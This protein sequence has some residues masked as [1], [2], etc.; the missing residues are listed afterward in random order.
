[1]PAPATPQAVLAARRQFSEARTVSDDL[2]PRPILRSWERCAGLGFDMEARPRVEP[3]TEQELRELRERHALLR[4]MCRPELEALRAEAETTDSIII[5]TDASG[6]LLERLGSADFA[7]RATR[8]ALSPGAAWGEQVT[9][10]NAI[11]T[12]LVERRPIEVRGPEHY[13]APHRFLSCSASPIFD[14]RGELVAILDLSGPAAVHHV[15]ALGLV[16][17]AADQIEHRLFQHGFKH[18]DLLRFHADPALI[19]TPREGILVFQDHRLV[20]ANRHG[21]ALLDLTPEAIDARRFGDLFANGLS[22]L[23]ERC[24]LRSHHGVEFHARL[25]RPVPCAPKAQTRTVATRTRAEPWLDDTLRA[26]RDRAVRLIDG[27]VPVLLQGETG[28]GKEVLARQVHAH[29][30]RGTGAFVAVNCAALPETLI[31]SELFGYV[32]GAFT[33]ARRQGATGLLREA[34]GGVLFLDE[35]GDMPLGLQS[36]LLRVLQ[37]REVTPLG[38]TRATPVDFA[39]ICATH[40]NLQDMVAQG[41]FRSDLYFRIAQYTI[42]L[43]PVRALRNLAEVITTLWTDIAGPAGIRLAPESL[44]LLA[45][46][47]WPGNFRQ[48]VATLRALHVLSQPD[49][50]LTPDLIPAEIRD[51]VLRAGR[52]CELATGQVGGQDAG[53]LAEVT[54]EAMR[55]ALVRAGGNV[56]RAAQQLGVNRSTIYRQLS[57]EL[58]RRHASGA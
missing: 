17:L 51:H 14:P 22:K 7:E 2:F 18:C 52:T 27:D 6:V 26:A 9:G 39:V 12:A 55:Q 40:R 41:A 36:R 57:N 28:V 35:I 33:G 34:H 1:M 23:D 16:R 24:R 15:H 48:L 10:T 37:E 19:G 31:E 49:R 58:A 20:A 11:G 4:R 53:R 21:L 44:D 45:A 46:Y 43:P 50:P 47:D 13:F 25:R 54:R 30:A 38:G 29:S 56:S 8:V 42:A 5:L 32:D 3:M